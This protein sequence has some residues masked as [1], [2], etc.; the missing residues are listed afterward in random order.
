VNLRIGVILPSIISALAIMTLV[1]AGFAARE[2]FSQRNAS[3]AFLTVNRISQLLLRSTGQWAIERGLSN[4]QLKSPDTIP[5]ERRAQIDQAR[6]NA[7]GAFRE[8]AALLRAVPGMKAAETNIVEA[9]SAVRAFE[10]F[11]RKVDESLQRPRSERPSEIVDGFAADITN[12]IDVAGNRLRLSLETLTVPPSASLVQLVGYRHV[13]A[14]MAESAGRERGHLSGIVSARAALTPESVRFVSRARGQVEPAWETISVMRQRR[15][16]PEQI[17]RA[18][19]GV[20]GEYFGKYA[21]TREAILAA[22]ESGDYKISGSEY[23]TRATTAIDSILAL[24]QALG[25]AADEEAAREA[26]G[27]ANGLMVHV[28]MLVASIVL[29]LMSFW[30]AFHRIVGPLSGLTAGMKELAAGNFGVV[31]PGLGRKDEIGDMAEAV[32][33]FKVKAEMKAREEAE[34]KMEQDHRVAEQRKVDMNRLADGFEHAVGRI[35]ETVLSASTELEAS[36]TALTA[37][38]DRGRQL[39]ATVAAASEQASTNVQSVASATE[40]LSSSISEIGRQVQESARV[41]GEAVE[42]AHSTSGRVGELSAAAARIGDVVELIRS[43]AAQTNL[44]ALNATIEAARAGEA[45]RGFAVVASEVKALAE[46]TSKATGEIGQQVTGIQTAT[47]DSV[48]AIKEIGVTIE[49]LSGISSTIAAAVE[50]QGAATQE[51]ARN[52]QRAAQGTQQV[53]HNISDVQRGAAETG[54]ASSQILASAHSLSHESGRLKQ[55]VVEFL[56]SVRAA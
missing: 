16:L 19:A 55:E 47:Q 8:A 46:Q 6:A 34:A 26:S 42:Q 3:E 30:V 11:R 27:S 49:R 1:S 41:A 48:G 25:S 22:G 20:E 4:G 56:N 12:L 38:A 24:A 28:A 40:Q 14:R 54:S 2:A 29:V 44:L 31:L 51:I 39:S 18:I 23:F 7:D 36:A 5:A 33:T 37:T 52:V 50:E 9:E 45:G 21:E 10:G 53:S 35:V 13:T 17:V 32:E 43:I 15:D